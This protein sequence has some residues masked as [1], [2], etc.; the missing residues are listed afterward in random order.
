MWVCVDILSRIVNN[1]IECYENQDFLYYSTE[2]G[3]VFKAELL[4]GYSDFLMLKPFGLYSLLQRRSQDAVCLL[5]RGADETPLQCKIMS[6][7]LRFF[8]FWSNSIRFFSYLDGNMPSGTC[9]PCHSP[10]A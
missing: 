10:S 8:L 7:S 6:V 9:P 4:R 3:S 5:N 1:E 2:F